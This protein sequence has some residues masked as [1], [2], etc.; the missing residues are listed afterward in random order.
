M[1]KSALCATKSHCAASSSQINEQW[2]KIKQQAIIDTLHWACQTLRLVRHSRLRAHKDA[3]LGWCRPCRLRQGVHPTGRRYS[4][5][6]G[7][8]P[9]SLYPKGTAKGWPAAP[10]LGARD[11]AAHTSRPRHLRRGC[12][13]LWRR[14]TAVRPPIFVA[15]RKSPVPE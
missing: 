1:S 2:T 6:Q 10:L 14:Q 11:L 5:G 4:G 15:A 8:F 13:R 7:D 3:A 12:N 9:R